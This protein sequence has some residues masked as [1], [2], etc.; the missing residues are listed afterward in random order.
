VAR[1]D[2]HALPKGALPVATTLLDCFL[3]A[4]AK[5]ERRDHNPPTS[6]SP[7]IQLNPA[8]AESGLVPFSD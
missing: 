7:S 4:L 2:Q 1:N 3:E 6:A 8:N 5:R